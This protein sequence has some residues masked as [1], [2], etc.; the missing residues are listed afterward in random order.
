M[1]EPHS[2][3]FGLLKWISGGVAGGVVLTASAAANP[4]TLEKLAEATPPGWVSL[5]TLLGAVMTYVLRSYVPSEKRVGE[6]F[7]ELKVG[8]KT[9]LGAVESL[10][11]ETRDHR[12]SSSEFQLGL[13][14]QI[15]G[16]SATLKS[17][18]GRQDRMETRVIS[19]EKKVGTGSFPRPRT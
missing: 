18:D 3:G 9:L 15:G 12:K 7:T 1:T 13:A 2:V 14:E 11:F 10:A 5:V 6:D 8:H 19:L 17:M 4:G 16:I